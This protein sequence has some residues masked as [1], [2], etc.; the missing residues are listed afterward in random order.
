MHLAAV[1]GWSEQLATT[2]DINLCQDLMDAIGRLCMQ[3]LVLHAS[4]P[5]SQTLK[6]SNACRQLLELC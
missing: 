2:Y 4:T 1:A 3:V 6:I 5:W